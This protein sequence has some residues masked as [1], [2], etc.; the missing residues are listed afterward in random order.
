MKDQAPRTTIAKIFREARLRSGWGVRD[1]GRRADVTPSTIS[2]IEKGEIALGPVTMRKLTAALPL[3]PA[4]RD[5]ISE[6]ANQDSARMLTSSKLAAEWADWDAL[7]LAL[8]RVT[9]HLTGV[10]EE[11][12]FQGFGT[13]SGIWRKGYDLLIRL[14]DQTWL[15]FVIK[16]GEIRV[17]RTTVDNH[18]ALPKPES[19]EFES[20]EGLSLLLSVPPRD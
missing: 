9:N 14:R 7:C 20:V 6:A 17:A 1:L 2:K 12:F 18:N 13:K 5:Q 10:T 4:E 19:K 11:D 15:G 8:I 3:S 16:P